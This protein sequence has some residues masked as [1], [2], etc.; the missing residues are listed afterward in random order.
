MGCILLNILNIL[1]HFEEVLTESRHFPTVLFKFQ[2]SA[3]PLLFSSRIQRVIF[4]KTEHV[5]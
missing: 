4:M 5:S 1:L 3:L 2:R